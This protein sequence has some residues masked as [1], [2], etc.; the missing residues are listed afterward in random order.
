MAQIT[1]TPRTKVIRSDGEVSNYFSDSCP[2]CGKEKLEES[3][4]KVPVFDERGWWYAATFTCKNSKC[5]HKWVEKLIS[6]SGGL[7]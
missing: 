4:G 3:L 6:P 7:R 1:I 2:L 5:G